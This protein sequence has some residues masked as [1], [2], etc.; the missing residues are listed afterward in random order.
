MGQ[1]FKFLFASCLG[2]ILAGLVLSFVAFS[3]VGGMV[4]SAEK[5]AP[6]SSNS[7]LEFKFDQAIPERTNNLEMNPFDLENQYIL[8]LQD[9]ITSIERAKTDDDIKGIF[10][11]LEFG[12]TGLATAS[13]LREALVDF[14]E[15]GKFII[16]YSKY[17]TQGAYYLGSVADKVYINPVG[18]LDMHG[19]S[20]MTPFY[21]SMLDKVGVEMKVFYAGKYKSA[22]EPFRRY[23]MSDESKLQLRAFLDPAFD[24]F[25]Q[26]I[27]TSRGKTVAEL[28]NYTDDLLIRT[29]DDAVKYGLVDKTAYYDEIQAEMRELIGMEDDDKVPGINFADYHK[30]TK[31]SLDFSVK[32]KIA[33]VYA[34]GAI[35]MGDGEPGS[36]G[37][38]QYVK[39]LQK[40]RKDDNI[41]AIVMRVNSPG[42]SPVASENIWRE[43]ELSQEAG[44]KVVVSMGDYAASGG[45]Y[46]SCGADKIYAE[47]NTLTGSIGVF[48][49]IPNTHELMADKIGM[50][51]D[52][53]KTT[54]NSQGL[55][56]YFDMSQAE[57]D[58]LNGNIQSTYALFKKRVAEGRNMTEE[59]V[60]AVAQGRV[61]SGADGKRVGLVDELGG[62]DDAIAEAAT[63]AGLEEYRT[64]EYP[65]VKE[66]L[67]K[68]LE[69]I[70]G[71]D[72]AI[73]H[74]ILQQEMGEFYPHYKRVKE[75]MSMKGVQATLP[76]MVELK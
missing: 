21:K 28:R 68:F 75:M 44:K 1:F 15:S 20:A 36:V 25:L 16:A 14:K 7:V 70:T 67:Q 76:V 37:D 27:A 74:K 17:Y 24:S 71:E 55:N 3:V 19:L 41:K 13:A 54:R 4:A 65:R 62:L 22:T 29:A 6:V 40:V 5:T 32:N 56:T 46:I 45:Y 57:I 2:T 38:E 48:M 52:T 69:E 61:W 59:A 23:E 12:G 50:T 33:V 11:N 53:V 49:M 43:L 35:N 73:T 42:G 30:A 31:P 9:Y 60:E 64:T 10:L 18:N 63:L 39:I 26:D 47:D 51:F 58:F 8:G 72:K 66:P 34:E